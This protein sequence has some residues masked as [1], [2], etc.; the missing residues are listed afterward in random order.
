[1]Q[2]DKKKTIQYA[3][4]YLDAA[5]RIK[6]EIKKLNPNNDN[7]ELNLLTKYINASIIGYVGILEHHNKF[8]SKK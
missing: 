1:M 3:Q 5:E 6:H 2:E 8:F 7:L 4:S